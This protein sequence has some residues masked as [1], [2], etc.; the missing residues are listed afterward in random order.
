MSGV[1]FLQQ[2]ICTGDLSANHKCYVQAIEQGGKSLHKNISTESSKP[3]LAV[4][5]KS[6][7]E[8]DSYILTSAGFL[9]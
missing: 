8:N 7:P 5:K 6:G 3:S 4:N 2:K 9:F 1:Y